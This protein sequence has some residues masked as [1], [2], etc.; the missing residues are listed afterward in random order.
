METEPPITETNAYDMVG[1]VKLFLLVVATVLDKMNEVQQG[2]PLKDDL[3]YDLSIVQDEVCDVKSE[4]NS[5]K[6]RIQHNSDAIATLSNK[7]EDVQAQLIKHGELLERIFQFLQQL[8]PFPEYSFR[9]ADRHQ[10]D[11]VAELNLRQ[12]EAVASMEQSLHNLV[13]RIP[14]FVD[15]DKE[16]KNTKNDDVVV[17][18]DHELLDSISL[19]ESLRMLLIII[20]LHKDHPPSTSAF[21]NVVEDEEDEDDDEDEDPEPRIPDAGADLRGVDDND[22][23]DDDDLSV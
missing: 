4:L 15:E 19:Y 10:L 20:L 22:D 16:R 7:A 9:E 13:S 2:M 8:P 1:D 18:S 11:M 6:M 3:A 5:M 12:A 14:L 21:T 17:I 23:D